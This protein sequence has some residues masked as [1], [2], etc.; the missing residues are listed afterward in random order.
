MLSL[1]N[2]EGYALAV[3]G[4]NS[5]PF[6]QSQVLVPA[7]TIEQYEFDPIAVMLPIFNRIWNTV[8]YKESLNFKEGK[9]V[10]QSH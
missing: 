4:G 5:N 6:R 9:W 2:I 7:Q 1:V 10:G 8:G 3:R